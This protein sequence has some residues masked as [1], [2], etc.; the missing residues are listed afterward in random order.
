MVKV[1][2]KCNTCIY[3]GAYT[4]SCSYC[5]VKKRSRLRDKDGNKIDPAY[6]DKYEEGR[7]MVDKGQWAYKGTSKD[8]SLYR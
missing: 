6:C 8:T 7:P 4:K 1:G 3:W 5:M 2:E